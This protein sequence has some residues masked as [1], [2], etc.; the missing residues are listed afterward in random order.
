MHRSNWF[1]AG[2]VLLLLLAF[3]VTPREAVASNTPCFKVRVE[4]RGREPVRLEGNVQYYRWTYRVYGIC[5]IN[6]GLSHWVLGLCRDLEHQLSDISTQS[7]DSSDPEN[8]T[9][10]TYGF[11]FGKDPRT[12]LAGLKW[13]FRLGNQVDKPGEY[14]EFSFIASG[15]VTPINWAA[16]GSTIVVRG[17]TY[18][19][20]CSPV[21]TEST[22]WSQIKTL[23]R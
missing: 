20:G 13:E 22:T 12:G 17:T 14:D 19:P 6:R 5:C 9:T 8:G 2:F 21:L 16:K 15:N 10:S 7:T 1:S 11:E 4:F 18:G 23:Y 3:G